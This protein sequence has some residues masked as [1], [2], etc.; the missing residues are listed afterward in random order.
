MESLSVAAAYGTALFEAAR[1]RGRLDAVSEE[2]SALEALF[3]AEPLFFELLCSPGV[4][5]GGKK[6]ALE[7]V[8]GG[9]LCEELLNFLF[10]LIDKRRIRQFPRIVRAY[11]KQVNDNLGIS[12]GTIYSLA[13]LPEDRLERFE[14]ETGKLLRKSVKLENLTDADLV[15]GV[16]ILIEGKLIDAS[17]RKRLDDLKERL[18]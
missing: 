8:L 5:A 12:V 16:R 2:M 1:D 11:Q 13:P 7:E 15:G 18:M 10:I 4:D 14:K 6:R 3:Q 17:I 9:R